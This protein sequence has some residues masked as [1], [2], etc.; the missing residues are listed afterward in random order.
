MLIGFFGVLLGALCLP[1]YHR[2]FGAFVLVLLGLSFYTLVVIHDYLQQDTGW[3]S[4]NLEKLTGNMPLAGGGVLA[5]LTV[6]FW[7]QRP[8]RKR[9]VENAGAITTGVGI[10]Q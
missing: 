7:R 3:A 5:A 6:C 10:G 2:R 8:N 1:N 9:N 4:C